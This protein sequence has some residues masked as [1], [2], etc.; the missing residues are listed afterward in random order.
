MMVMVAV[1]VMVMV[2][3]MVTVM[4]MVRV[5][6][7]VIIM[8]RVMVMVIDMTFL[9]V[10]KSKRFIIFLSFSVLKPRKTLHDL[11]V[12][13][14]GDTIARHHPANTIDGNTLSGSF[15]ISLMPL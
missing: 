14:H 9:I 2:T 1:M 7:R 10:E 6:V 15:H 13:H 12:Q 8:V 3:V 5:M 4:V 11:S